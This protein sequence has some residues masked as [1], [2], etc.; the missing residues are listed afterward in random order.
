M[1]L[2]GRTAVVSGAG[3]G[4]GR[5][6]AL[7]FAG[8]G[9]AVVLA[10][11]DAEPLAKVE[12]ELAAGGASVS[13]HPTD[14]SDPR[15]VDALA[16]AAEARFG[17]V[18]VVCNN[19]GVSGGGSPIWATTENDWSWVLGVNLMGV[20]HGIRAFVPRML[21]HGEP[22]HV[23]NTSSV[24]G[25][26]TGSGSIYSVT[27]HAVTRLSEGLWH[28]LR[29]AGSAIG[30]SVLCPGMVATRIVTAERNRPVHLQDAAVD[31]ERETRRLAMQERFLADGM[32]PELVAQMVVNAI[33]EG[34]FYVLTHPD[35]IRHQVEQRMRAIL[36]GSQPAAAEPL[37]APRPSADTQEIGTP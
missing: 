19:A 11:V 6:M 10:D 35:Q 24:L 15:A 30:V 5:A 37:V 9:M 31:S 4:I 22:G 20:V 14:V 21:A 26:S 27:K 32:P 13:A 34:R 2:S 1:R 17:P 33:E 7:R 25:L 18:H 23:V 28:D 3:S 29:A 8:E 12:R 16:D 36:D